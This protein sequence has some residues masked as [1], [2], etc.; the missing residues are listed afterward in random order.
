M[1]GGGGGG[2]GGGGSISAAIGANGGGGGFGA[3]FFCAAA[4]IHME[5]T[6]TDNKFFFITLV[7]DFDAMA[8]LFH[9][10]TSVFIAC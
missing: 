6:R 10:K 8:G 2:G 5:S 4:M 3:S 9:K 7:F 1:A